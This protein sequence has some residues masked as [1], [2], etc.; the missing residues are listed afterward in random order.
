MSLLTPATSI[1]QLTTNSV[2]GRSDTFQDLPI[3]SRDVKLNIFELEN[4]DKQIIN[5]LVYR[6]CRILTRKKNF[7]S[8]CRVLIIDTI[9]SINPIR[10][11]SIL[12]QNSG[13]LRK[14][15]IA[16]QCKINS[17]YLTLDAYIN[18]DALMRQPKL[19]VVYHD[20]YLIAKTLKLFE[21]FLPN[22][23]SQVVLVIPKLSRP[24]RDVLNLMPNN[25][26]LRCDFVVDRKDIGPAPPDATNDSYQRYLNQVCFQRY[27][28]NKSQPERM[29]G[30]LT[31]EGLHLSIPVKAPIPT[32]AS[33]DTV[34]FA[35]PVKRIKVEH[36][37]GKC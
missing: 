22:T 19:I 17:T 15:H 28:K 29:E 35:M 2:T 21:R 13:R 26:I 25:Q 16:R 23:K 4:S 32:R 20:E 36:N 31:E 3:I 11:G 37:Y 18:R 33:V 30:Y 10:L 6:F 8:E 7:N 24:D 34:D 1:S 12:K 14:I 5:E 9:G 27:S